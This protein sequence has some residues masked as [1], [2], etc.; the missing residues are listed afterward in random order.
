MQKTWKRLPTIDKKSQKEFAYFP[1]FVRQ[2][3]FNRGIRKKKEAEEFLEPNFIN[4]CDP[5]AMSGVKEAAKII[6]E[7]IKKGKKIFIHGDFDVDGICATTI[8]WDFLYRQLHADVLP[9]IPSRFD[10]GYGMTDA[11]L[12]HIKE[13]GGELVITV[14][15]GIKDDD[16]IK[17]WV[18]KGLSF[19]VTDHHEFKMKNDTVV[20]PSKAQ[21]I[22][23]PHYPQKEYPGGTISGSGV[24]WKLVSAISKLYAINFDTSIY[25]DLV[26]LS[27]VCDIMPLL[28]ENRSILK[29]GLERI[30]QTKRVGLRRLIY[31]AGFEPEQINA[32]HIG[33]IIGPRLNAAGRIE[34]ALDAVRLLSTKSQVQAREISE[35]LNALNEDR[36]RIQGEIYQKAIE[37]IEHIGFQHKLYF[38]WSEEWAEGVIGIVAGKITETYHRPVLIA[39]RKGNGYTGSARSIEEF[40]IIEAINSQGHLLE[41]FGGHPQAAGFTVSETN[42]E[43]FRDNLLK[44]ADEEISEHDIIRK[45]IVDGELS[46]S[47]IS[48][49]LI[50]WIERFSP[51]GY[52]NPTPKFIIEKAEIADVGFVG[53][54][55]NHI[56]FAFLNKET[57]EYFKGIGFNLGEE[58]RHVKAGDTVDLLTTVEIEEWNGERRI[59]L[60]VKDIRLKK[61]KY[62]I[63]NS[64]KN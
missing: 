28:G 1:S 59:Q 14:D 20:L 7:A 51:F 46:L 9:Y 43:I 37:Q 2:L 38:V 12:T 41:R 27:T 23:H 13:Q 54:T 58:Y 50:T 47:E 60:N 10:E 5:L 31:D 52:K 40:N 15:C 64:K 45:E 53:K 18:N 21:A 26:A 19:I 42:I 56:R 22:V 44:L 63:R 48:W 33:F 17:Q 30:R 4:F 57:G 8:L 39:T 24:V 35:K 34:H 29:A 25:L 6:K 55:K 62:K 61:T 3:L 11:S 32:Y 36:Q 16:L 49:D